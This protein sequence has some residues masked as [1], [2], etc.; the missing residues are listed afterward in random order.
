MPAKLVKL[1]NLQPRTIVE[2]IA[3]Y[4]DKEPYIEVS[5]SKNNK[6]FF[7][8]IY[9]QWKIMKYP[10]LARSDVTYY[11]FKRIDDAP[12]PMIKEIDVLTNKKPE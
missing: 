4:L 12:F 5:V 1:I 11:H 8:K 2:G 6:E 3:I 10:L 7:R 9:R